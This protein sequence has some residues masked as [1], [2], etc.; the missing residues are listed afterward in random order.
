VAEPVSDALELARQ[1]AGLSRGDLYLRYFELGGMS[2]PLELEAF[3]YGVL[4]PSAHD[5]DVVAH[6][7]NERLAELGRADFVAYSEDPRGEP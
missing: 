3:C 1:D 4:Q 5:H 7:I 2:S 6:V